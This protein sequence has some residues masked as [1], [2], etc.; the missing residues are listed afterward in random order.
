VTAWCGPASSA[1]LSK[2]D[3]TIV[4]EPA[5]QTKN[6]RY[7]LLV[8]GPEA[9]T[10][11]WLVLDG[12]TLYVDKTGKGDLTGSKKRVENSSPKNARIAHFW[13]GP[14]IAADGKTGYPDVVVLARHDGRFDRSPRVFMQV[15]LPKAFHAAGVERQRVS[16]QRK[17]LFAD[18]ASEAPILHIDGPLT[19]RLEDAKQVFVR[20]EK[21]SPLPV[22]VGTPGLGRETFAALIFE[23]NAPAALATITFPSR[24]AGGKPIVIEV[25]LNAPK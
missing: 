7:C 5:Y 9:R 18:R 4:K 16:E 24:K 23:S 21:P 13:L 22:M 17:L 15:D 10:R 3:R 19:F 14:I 20:G 25:P 6:P 8:F 11:V 1:D 2:I 12:T